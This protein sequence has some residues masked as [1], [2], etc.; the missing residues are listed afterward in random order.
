VPAAGSE[1]GALSARPVTY[2]V[3]AYGPQRLAVAARATSSC[4]KR[5]PVIRR[6]YVRTSRCKQCGR[7]TYRGG[8]EVEEELD[9]A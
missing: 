8:A 7:E 9:P 6:T 4:E 5:V 3:P 1:T 2:R